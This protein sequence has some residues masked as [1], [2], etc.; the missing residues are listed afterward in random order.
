[1]TVAVKIAASHELGHKAAMS[2]LGETEYTYINRMKKCPILF[3]PQDVC[4]PSVKHRLY[5][6]VLQSD[7][8]KCILSKQGAL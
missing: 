8:M 6:Y 5:V 1:M 4:R 7:M 2:K 3:D